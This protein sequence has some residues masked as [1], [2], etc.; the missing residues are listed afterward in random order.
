MSY[1]DPD[2]DI[3]SIFGLLKLSEKLA[4]TP[5]LDETKNTKWFKYY[6]V[7]IMAFIVLGSSSSLYGIIVYFLP[8]FKATNIVLRT[9]SMIA[10]TILNVITILVCLLNS[11]TWNTFVNLF[12]Y[13]DEKLNRGN[14]PVQR[15]NFL[16]MEILLSHFIIFCIFGYDA[17]VLYS[18]YGWKYVRFCLFRYVNCYHGT[19]TALILVHF[20]SALRARFRK[21]N[22]ML[23]KSNDLHNIIN[24][25]IPKYAPERINNLKSIKEV[26]DYY[27][28]L[29]E[30]VDMFN[31]LFGWQIF[32]MTEN[33][34]ISLLEVLNS[35]MLSIDY[36]QVTT[37]ARHDFRTIMFLASLS[38]VFI[39]F[40]SR[41]VLYC[42]DVNKESRNTLTISYNLQQTVDPCSEER[43]ELV[44]LSDVVNLLNT[45]TSAAGFYYI[46]RN[47]S[48]R[49]FGYLFSYS[50]VLIQF[51][52]Q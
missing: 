7:G 20:A 12:K 29:S 22:N 26:T 47:L 2:S 5:P 4:I 23:I 33:I 49:V 14:I 43:N 51:N 25:F 52:K 15:K 32:L 45:K 46:S 3:R 1:Y 34:I 36:T 9:I 8:L 19:I 31:K 35:L 27:L 6:A 10:L 42:E 40:H 13:V 41:I 44:I 48:S 11:K 37:D 30:L 18:N 21:I 39:V 24:N 38:L 28:L 17:Y 50:I 16:R